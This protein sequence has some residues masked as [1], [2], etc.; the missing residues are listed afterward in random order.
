MKN[1]YSIND[2]ALMSGL[3]TRT[4]RNYISVGL[5]KGSK[6]E[7]G[8]WKFTPEEVAAF[9]NEPFVKESVKV[10]YNNIVFDFLSNYNNGNRACVILDFPTG[11]KEANELSAFFC[12][13]MKD[14]KDANFAF[15][16]EKGVSRI[17]L[18]GDE[19]QIEIIMNNFHAKH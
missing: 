4:L 19:K 17:I 6:G 13:Q 10:K 5:L 7:D 12:E 2:L 16:Y 3:T 14:A 15:N 9:F 11:V 18:S 1:I 8:T